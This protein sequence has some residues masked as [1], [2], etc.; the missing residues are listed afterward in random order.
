[1]T[2]GRGGVALCLTLFGCAAVVGAV[3]FEQRRELRRLEAGVLL[4][5][6]REKYRRKALQVDSPQPRARN[7]DDSRV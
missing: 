6:E 5:L 3:H 4:D 1:M 2:M 7:E